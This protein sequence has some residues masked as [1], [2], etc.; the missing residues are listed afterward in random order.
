VLSVFYNFYC[1]F[2]NCI[3]N[4]NSKERLAFKKLTGVS[5]N[6]PEKFRYKFKTVISGI[7][8]LYVLGIKSSPAIINGRTIVYDLNNNSK[9][10]RINYLAEF[11]DVKSLQFVSSQDCLGYENIFQKIFFLVS[12]LPI[13][14]IL[15]VFGALKKDR[16]GIHSILSNLLITSNVLRLV[17]VSN[18]NDFVL[19]SAYDTNS[20]FLALTLQKHKYNVTTVSSEVPLYKWNSVLITDVLHLCSEYQI[21]EVKHLPNILFKKIEIG[22]PEKYFEVSKHYLEPAVPNK[23]LGFISTGGWVRKKLGHID[24][25]TDIENAE[26]RILTDLNIILAKKNQVQLIIYPHPRERKYFSDSLASLHD[27]YKKLLPDINFSISNSQQPTNTLFNETYLSVCFMTTSIFERLHAKRMSAIV[28]FKE[29]I[30][31]VNF[32]SEYLKFISSEAELE[33]L[34]DQVYL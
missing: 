5:F 19:F 2:L 21:E 25:G 3:F 29:S 34:I 24:Q 11:K 33:K 30:F 4:I 12:T 32:Y 10:D 28:Y 16:S 9:N 14:F 1:C 8:S 15:I 18:A 13:Q 31:P 27:F 26:N 17:R 7:V 6:V 20:A 23:K 22:V